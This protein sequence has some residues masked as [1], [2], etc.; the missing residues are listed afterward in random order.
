MKYSM[1]NKIAS[2]FTAFMKDAE[3]DT[4]D[5]FLLEFDSSG[6]LFIKGCREIVGYEEEGLLLDCVQFF[7]NVKGKDLQLER[8]SKKG[9]LVSGQVE[10]ISFMKR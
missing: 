8:F 10:S 4:D 6:A 7:V 2:F 3:L 1:P 9:T 5:R